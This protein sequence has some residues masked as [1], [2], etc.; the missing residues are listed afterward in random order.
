MFIFFPYSY[1][2]SFFLFLSGLMV[3]SAANWL[4][5]WFAMELNLLSF[6]PIMISSNYLHELEGT[7]K[8]FFTQSIGSVLILTGA[9]SSISISV[10]L[11]LLGVLLKLG[12]APFHFWFPSVMNVS[13]WE[14]CMILASWQKLPILGLLTFFVSSNTMVYLVIGA[15]SAITGGT[16]GLNQTQLRTILAYS[17]VNHTG[18]I[19][20]LMSVSSNSSWLY[21][22][23]YLTISLTLMST[24]KAAH[25]TFF[26]SSSST[27]FISLMLLLSLGGLPPLSGFAIK[28]GAISLLA[29]LS[30][31]ITL[32]LI[33][34]SLLG[35][36]YYLSL[37]FSFLFQ[38]FLSFLPMPFTFTNSAALFL[39]LSLMCFCLFTNL[40]IVL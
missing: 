38:S 3:L 17:A 25:S 14:T 21:F 39:M 1:L 31:P 35:L 34:G 4:S 37:A 30:V 20:A 40:F 22:M 24:L 2:F 9:L 27:T 15:M 29:P 26:W 7:M 33:Y 36:Y 18:W 11:S 5:A 13:S 16:M 10:Y 28:L 23:I 8:Y 6:I 19:L 12:V 32:C